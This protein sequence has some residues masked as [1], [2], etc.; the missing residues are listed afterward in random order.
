[1]QSQFQIHDVTV[2]TGQPCTAHHALTLARRMCRH[3]WC[4]DYNDTFKSVKK[5]FV[6]N[7]Y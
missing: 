4:G 1:M 7:Y 2:T 5:R 3:L 6:K